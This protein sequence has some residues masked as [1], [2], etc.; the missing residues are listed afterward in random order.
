MLHDVHFPL[1]SQLC[2]QFHESFMHAN[3]TSVHHE[4]A[5]RHGIF[6]FRKSAMSGKVGNSLVISTFEFIYSLQIS[7]LIWANVCISI[8]GMKLYLN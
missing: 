4:I 7:V 8:L 6:M 1:M 5:K 2:Y 3:F